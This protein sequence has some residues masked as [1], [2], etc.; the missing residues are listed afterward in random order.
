[1]LD[2]LSNGP[3]AVLA[4]DYLDWR[5]FFVD[6]DRVGHATS[7][8]VRQ[9][10][11]RYLRPQVSIDRFL[12]YSWYKSISCAPNRTALGFTVESM[13][14]SWIATNGCM[15]LMDPTRCKFFSTEQPEL[16]VYEGTAIYIRVPLKFNP[17]AVDAILVHVN[18]PPFQEAIVVGIQIA[19]TKNYGQSAESAFMREWE[20]YRRQ[21]RLGDRVTYDFL[22]IHGELDDSESVYEEVAAVERELDSG[23]S[24][25]AIPAYRRFRSTVKAESHFIGEK[26]REFAS[27]WE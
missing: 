11:V 14:I 10:A 5:Y 1:M 24:E 15:Y 21:L 13:M 19:I 18:R 22:L 25:I 23:G 8:I 27:M 3:T 26:L 6:D 4:G 9:I 2:C 17:R 16:E 20:T 7:E 12:T